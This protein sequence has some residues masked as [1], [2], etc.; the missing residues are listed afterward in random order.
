VPTLTIP[1]VL[2][3][4]ENA[5]ADAVNEN[6]S[7]VQ[8][9][10]NNLDDDNFQDGGVAEAKIVFDKTNGHDHSGGSMGKALSLVEADVTFVISDGHNHDGIKSRLARLAVIGSN[11]GT[12][13]IRSGSIS[14][15]STE[16]GGVITPGSEVITINGFDDYLLSLDIY[17]ADNAGSVTNEG[18]GLRFENLAGDEQEGFYAGQISKTGFTLVNSLGS[19]YT[20]YWY[21]IGV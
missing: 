9:T 13:K 14:I 16:A 18:V 1:N 19:T 17:Y 11:E 3:N 21:A 12:V 20:F 10:I 2:V 8:Q 5:D 15:T 6:F 7:A 4:G